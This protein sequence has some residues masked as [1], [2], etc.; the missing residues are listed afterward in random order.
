MTPLETSLGL[1]EAPVRD[2]AEPPEHRLRVE[3]TNQTDQPIDARRLAAA[4]E[5]ALSNVVDRR[6]AVSL[7]VVDDPT[8]HRLNRQFLDHDYATD[9]L[10]FVLEDDQERLEGEIIVS[11]DTA[12]R[13]ATEAG[14]RAADELM[15]Y[16]VHGALHLAG[17]GDK[18]PADVIA[19]RAA[20]VA[21]LDGLKVARSP[22]DSRWQPIESRDDSQEEVTDA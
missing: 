1:S 10:S 3:V 2:D 19:M 21:I 13:E 20:E 22:S 6:V 17:Y 18:Q 8:I 16:A 4:V 7:V 5:A 11:V 9:V 12:T 15:L 14:W